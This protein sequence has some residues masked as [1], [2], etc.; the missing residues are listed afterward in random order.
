MYLSRDLV[1]IFIQ[2]MNACFLSEAIPAEGRRPKAAGPCTVRGQIYR[3]MKIVPFG[4]PSTT[5]TAISNVF[6]A[7]ALV[8]VT[9]T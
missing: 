3:N 6:V 8:A 2:T 7:T 5:S 9:S 1:V 4:V